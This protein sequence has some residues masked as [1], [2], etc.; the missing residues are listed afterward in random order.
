[1]LN[2]LQ[3]RLKGKKA[4]NKAVFC[5]ANRFGRGVLPRLFFSN[6]RPQ[7]RG[8]ARGFCRR[9]RVQAG[10]PLC[11]RRYAKAVN[12]KRRGRVYAGRGKRCG[13]LGSV[14]AVLSSCQLCA[15]ICFA[16][17]FGGALAPLGSPPERLALLN[18]SGAGFCRACFFLTAARKTGARRGAFAAAQGYIIICA[19]KFVMTFCIFKKIC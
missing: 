12:K 6:S 17:N 4:H 9:A 7:N 13:R 19:Y 14:S 10:A 5:S 15:H 18:S 11:A 8:A 1:M 2:A 16:H 3:K